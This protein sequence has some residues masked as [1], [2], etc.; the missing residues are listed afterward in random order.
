MTNPKLMA[1]LIAK[2]FVELAQANSINKVTVKKIIET[3]GIS[4][5]TFYY[6]FQGRA[7]L[8]IYVFD[9]GLRGYFA[10]KGGAHDNFL[11]DLG[12]YLISERPLYRKLIKEA[13]EHERLVQHIHGL[14]FNYMR[15][16]FDSLQ[17]DMSMPAEGV[18]MMLDSLAYYAYNQI[19]GKIMHHGFIESYYASYA[20]RSPHNEEKYIRLYPHLIRF[21]AEYYW[22]EDVPE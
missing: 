14:I 3:C 1:G 10:Q 5:N 20:Q 21:L 18:Y 13:D 2:T 4:R 11:Y 6:H 9:Q 15:E 22:Q 19:V 7:E 17:L 8:M 16:V 12:N